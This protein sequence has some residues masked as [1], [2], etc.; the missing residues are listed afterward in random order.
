ML[1]LYA[2]LSFIVYF[3]FINNDEMLGFFSHGTRCAGAAT[4]EADNEM[5]GVGVAHGASIAG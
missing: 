4:G 2:Y 5:C 1:L 3:I